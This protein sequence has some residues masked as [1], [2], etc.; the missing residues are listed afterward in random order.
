MVIELIY[1]SKKVDLREGIRDGTVE[2][3]MGGY[4]K[5]SSWYEMAK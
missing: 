4:S 5:S 3:N 2:S 1:K